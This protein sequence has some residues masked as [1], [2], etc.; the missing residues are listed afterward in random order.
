MKGWRVSG[1]KWG[2]PF[3]TLKISL[4]QIVVMLCSKKSEEC[5][6]HG[7]LFSKGFQ[8]QLEKEL[9]VDYW[10]MGQSC[11][12]DHIQNTYFDRFQV[13][14]RFI[15]VQNKQAKNIF[16]RASFTYRLDLLGGI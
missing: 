15:N 10:D 3:K 9:N 4:P 6:I 12:Q 16:H 2:Y 13:I 8:S 1:P 14:W 7:W 5:E 11:G